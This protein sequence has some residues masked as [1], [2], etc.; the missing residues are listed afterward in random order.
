[1]NRQ[2]IN[3]NQI[4]YA[5]FWRRSAAFFIDAYLYTLL[6]LL[7]EKFVSLAGVTGNDTYNIQ[8]L[9]NYSGGWIFI[10]Y[11]IFLESSSKQATLGKIILGIKVI[12][13]HG[14]RISILREELSLNYYLLLSY[15]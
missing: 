6:I 15:G 9:I 8:K 14:K 7:I 10:L 12:D 5:G 1:M 4:S 2:S 13:I 11:F 3:G